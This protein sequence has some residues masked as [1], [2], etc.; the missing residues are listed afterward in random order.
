MAYL[1]YRFTMVLL[2][3]LVLL[4]SVP[5]SSDDEKDRLL[6]GINSYRQSKSLAPLQKHDKAGCLAEEIAEKLEDRPCPT[7][8]TPMPPPQL[9]TY[10]DQVDKCKIDINTTAD[11]VVLPVCVP[12]RVSTLVLTNYTQS[13]HARYLNSSRYNGVGVGM[14][15]DWTV[16]V[17]TTNTPG[18]TF[19]AG[20]HPGAN[21]CKIWMPVL[22]GFY[23]LVI[24]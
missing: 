12:K 18:G 15:E 16:L 7:G 5:A 23:L 22:V 20:E 11:G 10:R 19:A 17:L 9:A 1:G 14:E 2:L 6:Q 24:A 4:L 3:S 21:S 8:G 13:S